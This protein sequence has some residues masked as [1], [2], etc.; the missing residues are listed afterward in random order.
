MRPLLL[1]LMVIVSLAAT[2]CSALVQGGLPPL[3]TGCRASADCSVAGPQFVCVE[4]GCEILS[5]TCDD[6]CTAAGLRCHPFTTVSLSTGHQ[7]LAT[8]A[9]TPC[10]DGG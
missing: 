5:C 2:A 4:G 7:C 8:D 3:V 1:P 9:G 10:G 6:D